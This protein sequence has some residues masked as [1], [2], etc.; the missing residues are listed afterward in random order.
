M[1]GLSSVVGKGNAE[2]G[3]TG[4]SRGAGVSFAGGDGGASSIDF[5]P[6]VTLTSPS[7]SPRLGS[8]SPKVDQLIALAARADC[9]RRRRR[10]S[11]IQKPIP[12]AAASTRRMGT[13]IAAGEGPELP[14]SALALADADASAA[15]NRVEVAMVELD[16][17][18]VIVVETLA[19]VSDAKL[20]ELVETVVGMI[21][22]GG[23]SVVLDDVAMV[24]ESAR[25][26]GRSTDRDH[27]CRSRRRRWRCRR[28]GRTEGQIADERQRAPAGVSESLTT[29]DAHVALAI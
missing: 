7:A 23:L 3:R 25:Q 10:M 14:V 20:D 12:T 11:R 15:R 29:L 26:P 17:E 27:R 4:G 1:T 18:G 19:E 9:A 6:I 21:E 8:V 16:D 28:R 22:T 5:S 13:T 24:C 2:V